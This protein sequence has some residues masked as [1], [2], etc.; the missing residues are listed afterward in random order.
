MTMTN[1]PSAEPKGRPEAETAPAPKS[2]VPPIVAAATAG[3]VAVLGALMLTPELPNLP[4]F[5]TQP[6][7]PEDYGRATTVGLVSIALRDSAVWLWQQAGGLLGGI[8]R[9]GA[10]R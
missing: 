10:G 9:R 1:D 7:E 8:G 6:W 3:V 5:V 2:T 4:E